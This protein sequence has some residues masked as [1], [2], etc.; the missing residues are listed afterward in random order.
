[1]TALLLILTALGAAVLMIVT[2]VAALRGR[3]RSAVRL[4]SACVALV[5]TYAAALVAAGA[6]SRPRTLAHG[7]WKCF[8]D[9]C[10]TVASATPAA[11]GR[12]VTLL[13]RNAGRGRAQ[14]PDAAQAYLEPGRR[15]LVVAGLDE[16]LDPGQTATLHVL[17]LRADVAGNAG[18]RLVV[19]EG[20]WPSHA[21]IGDE[22]SP[23]H[24]HA[25]W[26]L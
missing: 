17:V 21:V 8:D 3:T 25:G 12:D 14:R 18:T 5:G 6:A 19:I 16:R 1:M 26:A 10:V 4:G 15:P 2:L 11:D 20:G 23:W 7:E 24:A 22:N 13:V 9:W